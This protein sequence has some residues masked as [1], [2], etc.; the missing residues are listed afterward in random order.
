M[1]TSTW[2]VVAVVVLVVIA[3]LVVLVMRARTK[4]L[5][6]H[7]ERAGEL[8]AQAEA[9][10]VGVAKR[11][12]AADEAQAKA[13]AARAQADRLEAEAKD[14]ASTAS[15]YE[16]RRVETLREA[17]EIDPDVDHEDTEQEARKE[18]EE[19]GRHL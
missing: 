16:R 3:A 7:R 11:A 15:D 18:S 9:Q 17:D 6:Q 1:D 5:D 13:Q 2:I 4:R 12:A 10:Q 19:P 14:I 8:R